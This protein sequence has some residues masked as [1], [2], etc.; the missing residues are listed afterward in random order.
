MNAEN[1]GENQNILNY[2][3]ENVYFISAQNNFIIPYL[4]SSDITN[5]VELITAR[6]AK[7]CVATQ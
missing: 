6:E 5:S 3:S 4:L 7:S 2:Q 1:N